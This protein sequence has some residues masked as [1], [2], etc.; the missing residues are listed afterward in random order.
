MTQST[1]DKITPHLETLEL[2]FNMND[3][4]NGRAI[5]QEMVKIQKEYKPD[6]R[7]VDT[8]CSSCVTELFKDVYRHYKQYENTISK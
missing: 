1:Y 2:I 3:G 4:G 7:P 5:F 8:G 6:A